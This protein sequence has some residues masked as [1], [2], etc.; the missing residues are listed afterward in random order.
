MKQLNARPIKKVL[1]A[2]GRKKMRAIRRLEKLKKKSD[3]INDDGG[4]SEADKASEI[5]S[6]VKKMTKK[7]KTKPKVTLVVATGTNKGL[8]GRPKG[9]KGKYKMVDGTLKNEMRAL[10]RIEKKNKK[11]KK[12]N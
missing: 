5:S 4:K 1:E 10:R 11:K 7:Q 12:R 3:L 8:S 2:Q 9:I 6:L